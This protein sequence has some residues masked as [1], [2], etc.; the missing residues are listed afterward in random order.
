MLTPRDVATRYNVSETTI[1]RLVREGK[2]P[3]PISIGRQLRWKPEDLERHDCES[4]GG[5]R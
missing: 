2:F 1:R 3:E 5:G 4:R